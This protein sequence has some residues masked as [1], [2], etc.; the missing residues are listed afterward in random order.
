MGTARHNPAPWEY[1]DAP[2]REERSAYGVVKDAEGRILFDSL[3]SDAAE[4]YEEGDEDSL[5]RWDDAARRNLGLA[6]L[7]PELLAALKGFLHADPDVFGAE[8]AA[9]RAVIAK[10]EGTTTTQGDGP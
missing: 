5:S 2:L 10:A 3:N 9:A 4:I 6:A 7:A 1:E 8:L